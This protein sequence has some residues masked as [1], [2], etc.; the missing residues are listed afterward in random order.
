V[1]CI[2]T[3]VVFHSETWTAIGRFLWLNRNS[4]WHI[5][6]CNHQQVEIN[7]SY[8]F[9]L[10]FH[11]CL[12]QYKILL[13]YFPAA[14][15]KWSQLYVLSVPLRALRSPIHHSCGRQFAGDTGAERG[16]TGA[17]CGFCR[18]LNRGCTATDI[19]PATTT[20]RFTGTSDRIFITL[21]V[22]DY[23][24]PLLMP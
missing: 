16:Q 13:V 11:K 7:G 17:A 1:A 12:M 8:S 21:R 19:R 23:R 10:I 22:V 15:Q 5:A 3:G 18:A 6:R 14:N 9:I 4:R 2:R 20:V 24:R